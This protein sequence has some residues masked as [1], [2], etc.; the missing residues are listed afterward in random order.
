MSQRRWVHSHICGRKDACCKSRDQVHQIR[1]VLK[2]EFV[3]EPF[4]YFPLDKTGVSHHSPP[5]KSEKTLMMYRLR[6]H[7]EET[8][9][10]GEDMLPFTII[11]LQLIHFLA[12]CTSYSGKHSYKKPVSRVQKSSPSHKREQTL[13]EDLQNSRRKKKA[14]WNHSCLRLFDVHLSTSVGLYSEEYMWA[15]FSSLEQP[16][17]HKLALTTSQGIWQKKIFLYF[18]KGSLRLINIIIPEMRELYRKESELEAQ[19][20]RD[21]KKKQQKETHEKDQYRSTVRLGGPS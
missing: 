1:R 8:C 7:K 9:V 5:K 17:L 13:R 12:E 14:S 19:I 16:L 6:K 21:N 15:S 3:Y 20:L 2:T 11:S 18:E 10:S 4:L